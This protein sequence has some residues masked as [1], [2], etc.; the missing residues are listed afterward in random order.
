MADPTTILAVIIYIRTATDKIDQKTESCRW[1]GLV[2][3][4]LVYTS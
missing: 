1:A 2:S 4:R 3:F